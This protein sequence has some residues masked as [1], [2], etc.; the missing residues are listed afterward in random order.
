MAFV[1]EGSHLA[2]WVNFQLRNP[3]LVL[4]GVKQ[5]P[6]KGNLSAEKTISLE[7]GRSRVAVA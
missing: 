4:Q 5:A 1:T 6:W 7:S 3:G 2:P